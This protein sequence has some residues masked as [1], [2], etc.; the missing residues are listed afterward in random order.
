MGAPNIA[1]ARERHKQQHSAQHC[2]VFFDS[3]RQNRVALQRP[4]G[5]R[6]AGMART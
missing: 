6:P 3:G 4:A 2:D 5:A 1:R